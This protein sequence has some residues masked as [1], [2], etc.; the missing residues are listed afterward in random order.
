M[1][2]FFLLLFLTGNSLICWSQAP[3]IEWQNTIG[4]SASDN[5]SAISLTDDAGFILGGSSGS[6]VFADKTEPNIGWNDYW[7]VKL[8]SVGSILWQS[9]IG[10]TDFD[11]LTSISQTA[12]GGYIVGGYSNSGISGN[13]TEANIGDYDIWVLKL[14]NSGNIIWQNTIGGTSSDKLFA[15]IVQTIDGGY[16]L[17]ATSNSN[18]SADKSEASLGDEDYWIIK[19]DNTGNLL[20]ENTIGGNSAD[21]LYSVNQTQNG[22]FLLGGTSISDVSGDK[23]EP[24]ILRPDGLKSIDYWVLEIDSAGNIISQQVIGG[25]YHDGLYD[26]QSGGI[27]SHFLGGSSNSPIS[28]DKNEDS[29]G[30]SD[31]WVIKSDSNLN[32]IW[33]K[34]I[35]GNSH[36]ELR[37]GAFTFL[38]GYIMAGYSQS[39]ISGN[40]TTENFGFE[41]YWLFKLDS[42]GSVLWQLEL[43]GSDYDRALIILQTPDGGYIVGGWSGSNSSATKDEDAIGGEDYWVIKLAPDETC[44]P[45][46]FFYDSDDDG[47][48]NALVDTLS[49]VPPDAYVSNSLDCDD[50]DPSIFPGAVEILN[51]VDDNCNNL[52]DEGL[53]EIENLP[54]PI[55]EI[56]PN[57]NNGNFKI[58]INNFAVT[59]I[60]IEIYSLNG[61]KIY[62]KQFPYSSKLLVGLPHSFSG[63]A[64]ALIRTE[65]FMATQLINVTRQ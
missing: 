17:G 39:G 34:T 41:D 40:K 27:N 10:G 36:D 62:S 26:I 11:Y 59:D 19:L 50:S 49:C 2:P 28:Y 63:I 48:G 57:P 9:T 64:Y 31:Y 29:Y 44:T 25:N 33:Q 16:I 4:G 47:F 60:Y 37:S 30:D 55:V 15:E 32:I 45:L 21:V 1:R 13:K 3:D 14:D 43:G 46:I 24:V 5:L 42:T 7:I 54:D 12:D 8:D 61:E 23:T 35:G 51:G 22:G 52:I 18:T 56:Y 58:D 65:N 38:K 20:W 6:N 53:V